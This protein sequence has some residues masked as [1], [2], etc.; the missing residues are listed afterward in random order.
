MRGA[1]YR[2]PLPPPHLI[3]TTPT[4]HLRGQG[5]KPKAQVGTQCPEGHGPPSAAQGQ[6]GKGKAATLPLTKPARTFACVFAWFF[7]SFN[8]LAFYGFTILK[9]L[10]ML[11]GGVLPRSPLSASSHGSRASSIRALSMPT[12]PLWISPRRL[13]RLLRIFLV[14][15]PTSSALSVDPST[16]S[17]YWRIMPS[18]LTEFPSTPLPSST[19]L[20][21]FRHLTR[22]D[23][24][25]HVGVARRR[26]S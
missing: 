26:R 24:A 17:S 4:H 10:N 1:V 11:V 23:V 6:Q 19:T 21:R 16:P 13:A 18:V 7:A 25:L 9:C 20:P 3:L 22:S 14:S 2:R 5:G 15:L 12:R 8:E